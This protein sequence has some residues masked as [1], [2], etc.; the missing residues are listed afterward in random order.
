MLVFAE[1][2][3]NNIFAKAQRFFQP[4]NAQRKVRNVNVLFFGAQHNFRNELF[5]LVEATQPH[6]C[7]TRF[8]YYVEAQS[9]FRNQI[10]KTRWKF[11]NFKI[12]MGKEASNLRNKIGV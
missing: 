5:C 3:T 2:G 8:S 9:N 10:Y 6:D 11:R 12:L 1:V 4:L 7:E